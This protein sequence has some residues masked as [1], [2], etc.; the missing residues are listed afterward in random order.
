MSDKHTGQEHENVSFENQKII[1]VDLE[2]EMRTAFLQYSMSVI[3]SRALPD[4]RDGL[5]PV[6]RRILYTMHEENLTPDKPFR[7]SATAVGDVLGRYHPHGDQSVYDALV[8]MAQPFSMRHML[9]DGHGNF[10]SVDGDPPAA[11]R[12][13]EARMSKL[14][15]EMLRYIEKETVDFIPNYDGSRKEPTVLPCL[16]PN[17]LVNGSSGIAV[18][19]ATNIPPHNLKETVGAILCVIDNEEA[20]LEDL[21]EHLSGP[22]F[23]TAGQ[24]YGKAGIRQAY[25]SGRGKVRVRAKAEIEEYKNKMRIVVSELPYQVNK[26]ELV[27]HIGTLAQSK[28]LEGISALRDESGRAGMKIVID[29]KRDAN[30]QVVLNKLYAQTR[31]QTTFAINMIALVGGQPMTL[32]LRPILDHYIAHQKEV[33]CRRTEYDLRRAL[34][35]M[36]LLEGLKIA[37]DNIDEVIKIIRSSYNNAKSRLMERF[38]L[39]DVQGQAIVDMR[40]GRLQGLEI[41]KLQ[42]EIDSLALA[43][44]DYRDILAKDERVKDIL[45]NELTTLSE[46]FGNVRRTE[47]VDNEDEIDLEDLIEREDC[48]YTL[49]QVGYMKRTPRSIYRSQR[50]GGRGVAGQT[51]RDEDY[52]KELFVASTHDDIY[53]FTTSGRMFKKRGYHVPEASRTAKGLNL[54][55]L[56]PLEADETVT[57]VI[58]MGDDEEVGY[59]FFATKHGIV[60][61]TR[62]DLFAS[63]GRKSG[64]RAVSLDEGDELIGVRKTDGN[65]DM[66]LATRGGLAICFNETGVREVGRS[67]RGVIG[68]RLL[69]DDYVIDLAC[70]RAGAELLTVT[71]NGFGKRTHID[72]YKRGGEAQ[73]RGGKGLKN[74]NLTEQTGK[75]AGVRVVDE[76]DDIMFISDDGVI[77]RTAVAGIRRCSRTSKGVILMRLAK[78]ARVITLARTFKEEEEEE[79]QE[80][81][82]E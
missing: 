38:G 69:E 63:A 34:E 44:V 1:P 16:F 80:I 3:T 37:V 2:R 56:L 5:K 4:V 51:V 31:M 42:A 33:I 50:R 40:L 6:H 54:A 41:E 46:R 49:T 35:R 9:I 52:I 25:S 7:K 66:L 55:N 24:I 77:I 72:E 64:L 39:S 14:A 81:H 62:M 60:K 13:T 43:I 21:M 82:E 47:I 17:L 59:L 61:R 74:Q 8:R 73:N 26:A 30:A 36:H 18:G 67:A 15:V 19:M 53:F 79:E 23:P 71:E 57:S 65:Q 29:L 28:Q 27:K 58:P 45:R 48:V 11:Y 12:Y 10:G 68:I 78:G 76:D 70:A 32:G 22:D 20:E 75:V